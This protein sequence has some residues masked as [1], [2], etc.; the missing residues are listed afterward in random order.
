[1]NGAAIAS[2]VGGLVFMIT[3][4]MLSGTWSTLTVLEILK[5]MSKNIIL[6]EGIAKRICDGLFDTGDNTKKAAMIY[7]TTG[8]EVPYLD[9]ITK[10]L[11]DEALT[12]G[13]NGLNYLKRSISEL[14]WVIEKLER[15]GIEFI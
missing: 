11:L 1:M 8:R 2:Q 9:C 7:I 13:S 14:S 3:F 12:G 10:M 4:A 5:T 6:G 15:E